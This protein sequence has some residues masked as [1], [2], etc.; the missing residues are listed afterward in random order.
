MTPP[1]A[2]AAVAAAL[3]WLETEREFSVAPTQQ[4][5]ESYASRQKLADSASGRLHEASLARPKRFVYDSL[6]MQ[7]GTIVGGIVGGLLG[8]LGGFLLGRYVERKEK[9]IEK[10]LATEFLGI[11]GTITG[12]V[13]AA[14]VATAMQKHPPVVASAMLPPVAIAVPTTAVA[15]S[16]A[17]TAAAT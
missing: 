8:G 17:Q 16:P 15:T 5:P 10:G 12:G 2:A 3:F 4:P 6:D 14:A 7:Q 13:A 11:M 1:S 9:G